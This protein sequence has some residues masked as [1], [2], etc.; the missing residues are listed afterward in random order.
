MKL[1]ST[2][3]PALRSWV[4]SANAPGC[5]FPVQNLPFGIFRRK[6][7]KEPPRGGVASGD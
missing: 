5:H 1:D 7:S 4:E 3:D 2:H 6:G